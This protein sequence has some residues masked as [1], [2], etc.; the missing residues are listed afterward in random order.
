MQTLRWMRVP[1]DS[2]FALGELTMVWFVFTLRRAKREE[3]VGEPQPVM[4]D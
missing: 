2:I 4:G 1:S 3:P